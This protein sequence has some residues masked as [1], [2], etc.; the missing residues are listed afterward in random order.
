MSRCVNQKTIQRQDNVRSGAAMIELALF[1]PVFFIITMG[2]IE[3]CRMLYL[4]QSLTIAAYECARM[5]IITGMTHDSLKIQCD[6]ILLGRKVRGAVMKVEPSN[7]QSLQF[8]D[9]LT[10]TVEAPADDNALLGTWL[11][12]G[13]QMVET[14]KIMAEH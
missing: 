1:L 12:R 14:V 8:G 11:Y 9:I 3:T 13:K 10:V 5:G 7:L 6:N 4:R 2:T